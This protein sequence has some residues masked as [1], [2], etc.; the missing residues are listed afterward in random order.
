MCP[1]VLVANTGV[2]VV[3][4]VSFGAISAR[5]QTDQS[6]LLNPWN[7]PGSTEV[8][9]AFRWTPDSVPRGSAGNSSLAEYASRGRVRLDDSHELNPVLGFDAFGLSLRDRSG[10]V[11]SG[12]TDSSIAF[13]SPI[14]EIDDWFVGMGAGAGYAGDRGLANSDAWY[15]KGAVTVGRE[16][17]DGSALAIWVEYDGNRVLFPD[18]P[19]PGIAYAD[20][21]DESFEYVLGFPDSYFAWR[22]TETLEISIEWALPFTIDAS[23]EQE[24]GHGFSI[25][26]SFVDQTHQFHAG[27]LR[28]IDRL[29]FNERR[30]EIGLYWSPD[31]RVRIGAI[32]GYAFDRDFSVGFDDRNADHLVGLP[33]RPVFSVQ[34]TIGF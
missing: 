6:L 29:M 21:I 14:T 17:A 32:V 28:G 2:L 20:K 10:R 13:A 26:G 7:G 23:I 8:Q 19:L 24:L 1:S 30:L 31:P 4:A 11:P 22:P 18:V 12:L 5:A 34:A 27:R 33:D 3:A 15:G 9:A 25:V 16:F